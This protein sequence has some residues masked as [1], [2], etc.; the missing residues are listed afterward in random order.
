MLKCVSNL[1]TYICFT[2]LKKKKK[3][4]FITTNNLHNSMFPSFNLFMFTEGDNATINNED[5]K[6]F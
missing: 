3:D 4:L 2:L 6:E 5:R 1:T